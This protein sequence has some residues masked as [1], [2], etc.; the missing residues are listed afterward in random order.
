MGETG[1]ATERR[2]MGRDGSLNVSRKRKE[3]NGKREEW[4]TYGG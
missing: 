4:V 2:K 1:R 3:M